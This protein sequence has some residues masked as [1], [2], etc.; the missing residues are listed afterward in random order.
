MSSFHTTYNGL[1]SEASDSNASANSEAR[2]NEDSSRQLKHILLLTSTRKEP[3]RRNIINNL[4]DTQLDSLVGVLWEQGISRR[5]RKRVRLDLDFFRPWL[6][7]DDWEWL[8]GS[9]TK[10]N[11]AVGQL[12]QH[13]DEDLQGGWWT[14]VS[15][16]EMLDDYVVQD[17]RDRQ[18]CK[19][20]SAVSICVRA[21]AW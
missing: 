12:W 18:G 4:D 10:L 21:N 6:D 7:P 8:L 20:S 14:R 9:F 11:E 3:K 1:N 13:D 17:R 5:V 19:S 2:R 16:L 15:V